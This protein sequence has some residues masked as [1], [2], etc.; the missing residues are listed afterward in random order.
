MRVPFIFFW[1]VPSLCFRLRVYSWTKCTDSLLQLGPSAGTLGLLSKL[2]LVQPWKRLERM[3]LLLHNH[4]IFFLHGMEYNL[5]SY[6]LS[7]L[8]QFWRTLQIMWVVPCAMPSVVPWLGGPQQ[9]PS[10]V[11]QLNPIS[12]HVEQ[13]KVGQSL[14]CG[15]LLN[16]PGQSPQTAGRLY[17]KQKNRLENWFL[18]YWCSECETKAWGK[19][20]QIK[21][22]AFLA[23]RSSVTVISSL[24]HLSNGSFLFSGWHLD[25]VCCSNISKFQ[26]VREEQKGCF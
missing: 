18:C 11:Q 13:W 19:K 2:S 24:F 22:K 6:P 26:E 10:Y 5:I 3:L 12:L 9:E 1:S 23:V 25:N 8:Y 7:F 17:P 4:E 15:K 16:P 21:K 14:S 20:N